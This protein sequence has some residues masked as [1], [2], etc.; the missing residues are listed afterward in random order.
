MFL[1]LVQF[2]MWKVFARIK[3]D[4]E[5]AAAHVRSNLRAD[6]FLVWHGAANHFK[7]LEGVGGWLWLTNQRL[8]FESHSINGQVHELVIPL[9]QVSEAKPVRTVWLIPNGLL[10]RTT[11]GTAERFVVYGRQTWA[12]LINRLAP[13]RNASPLA[14]QTAML[15]LSR[16]AG[17]SV[18]IGD[19]VLTVKE[20]S[21]RFVEVRVTETPGGTVENLRMSR[22]EPTQLWPG[23]QV[24]YLGETNMGARFQVKAPH[25]MKVHRKEVWEALQRSKR[26]KPLLRPSPPTTAMFGLSS[27]YRFSESALRRAHKHSSRHRQELS[28]SRSC[29]CFGCLL[30]FDYKDIVAW[31]DDGETAI[32]PGCGIDSVIG[33]A[34]GVPIDRHFLLAM[35]ERWF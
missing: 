11:E 20:W 24:V 19:A 29:G 12:A 22:G 31:V 4:T 14:A 18:V 27:G 34:S 10:L 23:V 21:G 9:Q 17:E 3:Q 30:V 15:V 25:D 33:S 35:K 7:R 8:I 13:R 32:C 2:L 28:K 5:H 26:R 6:E 1:E 16:K